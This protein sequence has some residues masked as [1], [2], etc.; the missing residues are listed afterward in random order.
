MRIP[1]K[2]WHN[3]VGPRGENTIFHFAAHIIEGL[4]GMTAKLGQLFRH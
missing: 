4:P 1:E 2:S 3:C